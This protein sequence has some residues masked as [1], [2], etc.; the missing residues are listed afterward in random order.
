[1]KR[2]GSEILEYDLSSRLQQFLVD[3]ETIEF[4]V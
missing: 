1:M 3:G 2:A 4:E